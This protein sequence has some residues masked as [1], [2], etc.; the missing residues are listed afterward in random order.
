[1]DVT[2]LCAH[3]EVE[4]DSSFILLAH[5]SNRLTKG[6]EETSKRAMS[7]LFFSLMPMI[8]KSLEARLSSSSIEWV[9]RD[10][11]LKRGR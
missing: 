3:S 8:I 7:L 11:S 1:M 2:D 9:L 5:P 6:I 10:P 4:L